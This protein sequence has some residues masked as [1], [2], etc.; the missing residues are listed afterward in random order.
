MG[1]FGLD[2]KGNATSLCPYGVPGD[3]LWVR[4]A[5]AVGKCA[6]GFK[7]R[8]LDPR[9]W[10]VDNGG[11]WFPA[12]CTEP[13]TP[14]S[15]RGKTRPGIFLPRWASRITLEVT[16]VRVE[17]LQ[18]ISEKDC[19]AEGIYKMGADVIGNDPWVAPGVQMTNV[20]GDKQYE[21]P[22]HNTAKEAYK[23]LWESINGFGSWGK[24]PWIWVIEFKR[25]KP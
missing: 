9:T 20:Y 21:V 12:D 23:T 16:A 3:R 5:W 22:C 14:I 11:L 1:A 2:G 7:P 8:M 17:R 25:I 13:K 10:K 19:I 15:P 6:D 4:E 18:E 24:N